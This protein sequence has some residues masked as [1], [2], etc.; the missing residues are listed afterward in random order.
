MATIISKEIE[1]CAGHR[2]PNHKSKCRNIHGHTYKVGVALK[3]EVNNTPGAS[4][5][6]M[7]LDF[8]DL[9]SVM[10]DYIHKVFDHSFIVYER[11]YEMLQAVDKFMQDGMKIVKINCIPTAEN[12]AQ[13]IWDT[14]V[15]VGFNNLFT[16]IVEE[17]ATSKAIYTGATSAQRD[18]IA[19]GTNAEEE[20]YTR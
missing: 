5:E 2:V 3:G 14:L 16:V 17:S 9:K 18:S 4:D 6:G 15:E 1:F 8:G 7:V 11:D 13:L 12:L 20:Q 10:N 19:N